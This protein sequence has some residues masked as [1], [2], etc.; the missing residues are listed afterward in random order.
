[1]TK[2]TAGRATTEGTRIRSNALTHV[3]ADP[4]IPIRPIRRICQPAFRA[5]CLVTTRRGSVHQTRPRLVYVV[6]PA[7]YFLVSRVRR[8]VL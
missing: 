8:R 6:Q 4:A 3:K 5:R 7:N 2:P 1:M